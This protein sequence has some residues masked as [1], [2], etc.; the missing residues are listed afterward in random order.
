[1]IHNFIS[2]NATLSKEDFFQ[3][4]WAFLCLSVCLLF[5]TFF[6]FLTC[7]RENFRDNYFRCSIFSSIVCGKI[8]FVLFAYTKNMKQREIASSLSFECSARCSIWFNYS[9]CIFN[10]VDVLSFG[11]AAELWEMRWGRG[12]K[13]KIIYGNF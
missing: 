7:E 1:M 10:A 4:Q 2:F 5:S 9:V 6:P 12:W 8:I 13:K 11:R 3:L